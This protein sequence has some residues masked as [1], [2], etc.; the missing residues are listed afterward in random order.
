MLP[1]PFLRRNHTQLCSERGDQVSSTGRPRFLFRGYS[2]RRYWDGCI[3]LLRESQARRIR[4]SWP[5]L[6]GHWMEGA[7]QFR[8]ACE[9][10]SAQGSYQCNVLRRVLPSRYS[11]LQDSG[12]GIQSVYLTEVRSPLSRD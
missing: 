11:P 12:N 9:Q 2:Y 4:G 1:S 3:L 5:E 6:G 8:I 7:G 10:D